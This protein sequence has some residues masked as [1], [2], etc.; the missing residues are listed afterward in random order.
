MGN[1]KIAC[2]FIFVCLI[3][4]WGIV[5]ATVDVDVDAD[6]F[7]NDLATRIDSADELSDTNVVEDPLVESSVSGNLESNN[8]NANRLGVS[9]SVS[10]VN[11]ADS[12]GSS[13]EDDI[14]YIIVGSYCG[15]TTSNGYTIFCANVRNSAPSHSTPLSIRNTSV[16]NNTVYGN[17]V[18]ELLKILIY[19]YNDGFSGDYSRQSAIWR[20]TNYEYR[21][22]TS[23]DTITD[24]VNKVIYDYDNGVRIPE[25]AY[26]HLDNGTVRT[27]DFTAFLTP[28]RYQ[29]LFWYKITDVEI[30]KSEANFNMT[31]SKE[32]LNKTAE[33]GNLTEF[34]ITVKNIGDIH[35]K[36]VFVKE[37]KHD[38]LEYVSY[39]DPSG[40]WTFDGVNKW[41]YD[42]YL[43]I[44]ES[45]NFT[46]IFKV[47]KSGNLTNFVTAGSN[48]TDNVTDNDT[49]EVENKTNITEKVD[50]GI[51]YFNETDIDTPVSEN[52]TT[53][54][55]ETFNVGKT[56]TGN[57]LMLLLVVISLIGCTRFRKNK[58]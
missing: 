8:A 13:S 47:I 10:A 2:M 37:G 46:V 36:D 7:D 12:D 24:V 19:N 44:G 35:L 18:S 52:K 58:K 55:T 6:V 5:S 31:V 48:N 32:A 16:L 27:Y 49:V 9:N 3:V 17:N 30:L 20:L 26:K 54:K 43:E 23:S 25:K 50:G 38:G 53:T 42:G 14:E 33:V 29:D 21:N 1:K 39:N 22:Y 34:L 4:S 51:K 45:V 11:A 15:G 57:P 40:K 28:E 41:S 56:A